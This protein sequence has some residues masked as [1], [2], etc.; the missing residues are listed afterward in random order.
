MI[1]KVDPEL[2]FYHSRGMVSA[3]P[4]VFKSPWQSPAIRTWVTLF[5]LGEVLAN[6]VLHLRALR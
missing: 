1:A 5:Q 6:G 4:S 3:G 2:L